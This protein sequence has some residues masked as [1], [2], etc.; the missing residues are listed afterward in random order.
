MIY[1]KT[2]KHFSTFHFLPLETSFI[3]HFQTLN[4][5][6]LYFAEIEVTISKKKNLKIEKIDVTPA[7]NFYE[8]ILKENSVGI[9][10]LKVYI[11][12]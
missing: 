8:F 3:F 7:L 1:N 2:I 4:K 12:N 11:Q 10:M 5:I 9:I 6:D